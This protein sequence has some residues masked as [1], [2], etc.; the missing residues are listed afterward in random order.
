MISEDAK[1]IIEALGRKMDERELLV[2][3]DE[4]GRVYERDIKLLFEKMGTEKA[5]RIIALETER[6]ERIQKDEALAAE[7][8]I[9]TKTRD[10]VA[11]AIA[12]LGFI[13]L[14]LSIFV[15][16]QRVFS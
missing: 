1:E 14:I 11:G 7:Q 4:R 12:L 8:K 2:R 3:I 13:S 15:A 6:A 9:I 10:R 16:F 5:E